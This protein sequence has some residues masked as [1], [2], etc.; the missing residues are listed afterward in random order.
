MTDGQMTDGQEPGQAPRVQAPRVQAPSGQAPRGSEEPLDTAYDV[1]LLDLDGVVYLGGA[2]IPGAA[3]ALRKA[4]AAGMRLAYVTNNAFRTPAA[5]AALLTSFG[6]PAAPEDVVTSAQAAARL[7]AERL[8][9]GAP[10]LVIGGSGLRMAVRERGLRPVSTAADRPRAV[11]QGYS[12]DVSYLMLAEGGLAVAAGALFVA[13]NGDLTLPSR[14]GRQ[15]GNGSLIQVVAT[16]TGVQ[17]LVAGKPEPPLHRE[18]VLR[19]GARHPL[20]VGDRLDTDIEGA[21]RVGADSMLVLT[22]VTGPAEVVLAPP[23]QRPTYLAEDLA[24]LLGPHP[25]VTERDGV[26]GCGGW[27]ARL[28]GDR[29][30][31]TG[32]GE[33]IDGLRAL[34]AAA[35]IAGAD[36]GVS[37]EAA[38]PAIEHLSSRTHTPM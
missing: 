24:G 20:V 25:A 27:T 23:S 30:E 15:P 9:A 37:S 26:F 32:D 6:V 4:D 11:V 17:P 36:G 3:E 34:C 2:A 14:R 21:R 1:A 19:T 33:R 18:S 7:L 13:S 35:W 38:R 8:P 12:P 29:L 22:G 10:V 31:L 28:G 16:A 5:I